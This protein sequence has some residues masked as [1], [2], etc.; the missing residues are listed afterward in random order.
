MGVEKAE[1]LLEKHPELMAY[2][3]YAGPKGELKTWYSPSMKDK[4]AQ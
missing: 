2:F 3:I 1:A 4:I